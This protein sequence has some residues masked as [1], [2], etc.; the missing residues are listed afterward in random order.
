MPQVKDYE[1]IK[2]TNKRMVFQQILKEAPISRAELSRKTKMSPTTI[3]RIVKELMDEGLIQEKNAEVNRNKIGR[4]AIILDVV[5]EA[6][7][8]IGLFI[9]KH[10]QEM[11]ILGL[12]NEIISQEIFSF[13]TDNPDQC[14]AN[15]CRNIEEQIDKCQIERTNII[16][17]GIGLP[18]V[19]DSEKGA[20]HLSATLGW[21]DIE[22]TNKMEQQLGLQTV[23]DNE[24]KARA[25]AEY[26]QGN[27]GEKERTAI[28][29]FG[30]GVG[31]ALIIADEVYR[32]STNSA[33]EIGHT[34]VEVDGEECDC[35]KRG[36]LQM[37]IIE[38]ALIK[39]AK[40]YESIS[41]LEDIFQYYSMG[42]DWAIQL[43]EQAIKYIHITIANVVCMYNPDTVIVDGLLIDKLRKNNIDVTIRRSNNYLWKPLEKTFRTTYSLL[44]SQGVPIGAGIMA[45]NNF[46]ELE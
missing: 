46:F 28:I 43:I 45:Q 17:V 8:T 12:N 13:S 18:G 2:I 1:Y 36:C 23:I 30:S 24:L 21:N 27:I 4:R 6:I 34:T 11:V 35:G 40:Q 41:S 39:Q 20:L 38:E 3:T 9:D 16:G 15:I 32:G 37:Y 19:I 33:G 44:G 14:I 7:I 29:S 25:L 26:H 5:P 10:T 42:R 31:S 22:I